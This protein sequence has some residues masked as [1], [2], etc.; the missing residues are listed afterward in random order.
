M[1]FAEAAILVLVVPYKQEF[2]LDLLGTDAI[3]RRSAAW[4][5]PKSSAKKRLQLRYEFVT[6]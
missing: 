1:T 6:S 4:Q 5:R 2:T 3:F